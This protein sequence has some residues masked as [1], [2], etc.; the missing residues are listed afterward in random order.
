MV[1]AIIKVMKPFTHAGF[2]NED[3]KKVAINIG[4]YFRQHPET[5]A[6]LQLDIIETL[7]LAAKVENK[8][9]SYHQS[10]VFSSYNL[11]IL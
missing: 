8:I 9:K 2:L 5:S 10:L 6:S 1:Q 7:I 4:R 3:V 11:A